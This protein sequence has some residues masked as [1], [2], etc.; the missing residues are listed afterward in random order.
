MIDGPRI[1]VQLF[2][3]HSCL[4]RSSKCI[5]T[6]QAFVHCWNQAGVLLDCALVGVHIFGLCGHFSWQAQG[7]PRVLVVSNRRFVAGAGDRS[8][9]TST[10]RF[11][12][13]CNSQSLQEDGA[14][15]WSPLNNETE[16]NAPFVLHHSIHTTHHTL[17]ILHHSSHTTHH[18]P[19]STHRSSHTT[20]HTPLISFTLIVQ[21]L[22]ALFLINLYLP[23]S[24]VAAVSVTVRAIMTMSCKVWSSVRV[25]GIVLKWL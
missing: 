3:A 12:G 22:S 15:V 13:K 2:T 9:S 7:N 4:S 24:S 16:R 20:H 1:P 10:W 5:S 6:V 23:F 14:D 11:R 19:L 21:Y 25:L 17:L 8:N 18:T